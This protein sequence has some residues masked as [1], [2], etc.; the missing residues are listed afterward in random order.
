M[1]KRLASG[2]LWLFA[3]WYLGNLVAFQLSVSMLI[4]PLLGVLAA[5]AVAG[6]PFGLIWKRAAIARAAQAAG[7]TASSATSGTITAD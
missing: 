4:G 6:D 7:T 1:N 5:L 2:V 3:G